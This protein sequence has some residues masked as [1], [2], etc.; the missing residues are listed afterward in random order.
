MYNLI[1][2]DYSPSEAILRIVDTLTEDLVVTSFVSVALATGVI[3]CFILT[4]LYTQ[5][6]TEQTS[7]RKLEKVIIEE[8]KSD[9]LSLLIKR[10]FRFVEEPEPHLVFPSKMSSVLIS[11]SL[12]YAISLFFLVF[13]SEGMYHIVVL[14]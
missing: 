2:K 4:N 14:I 3:L 1:V 9:N 10:M 8:I 13:I 11:F 5:V 12:Y 7:F 6:L